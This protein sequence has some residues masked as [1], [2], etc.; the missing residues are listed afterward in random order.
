VWCMCV[1]CVCEC[2]YVL[3]VYCMC[4]CVWCVYVCVV[5][6]YVWCVYVCVSVC[7]CV[8]CVCMCVYACVCMCVCVWCGVC[9]CF[10]EAHESSKRRKQAPCSAVDMQTVTDKR[11]LHIT[12]CTALLYFVNTCHSSYPQFSPA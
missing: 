11:Q 3:C 12:L 4:E 8:Y 9:M 5:C 1:W 6:V 7:M 10:L 2:V